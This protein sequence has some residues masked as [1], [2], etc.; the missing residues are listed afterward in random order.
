M[1]GYKGFCSGSFGVKLV[2][3][4]LKLGLLKKGTENLSSILRYD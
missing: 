2:I 3:K 4:V 1:S